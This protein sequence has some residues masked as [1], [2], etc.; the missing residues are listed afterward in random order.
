VFDELTLFGG[1]GVRGPGTL[2]WGY[3]AIAVLTT[4][5][6]TKAP[7]AWKLSATLAARDKWQVQQAAKLKELL[8]TAPRDKG[9]WCWE[10]QDVDVGTTELRATLGPPLQ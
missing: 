2:V 6:I 1:G 8:F 3:R 9:R 5:R 10:L 7:G 4:W